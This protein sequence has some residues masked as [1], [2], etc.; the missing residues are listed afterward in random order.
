M[1]EKCPHCKSNQELSSSKMIKSPNHL[2]LSCYSLIPLAFKSHLHKWKSQ[3]SRHVMWDFTSMPSKTNG[4]C[5]L[6]QITEQC[7]FCNCKW[8]LRTGG[9]NILTHAK[10]MTLLALYKLH[11]YNH[12]CILSWHRKYFN[13]EKITPLW[14][15]WC[16]TGDFLLYQFHNEALQNSWSLVTNVISFLK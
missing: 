6:S 11:I 16:E 13:T 3:T 8:D 14:S 12:L 5:I 1:F 15:D 2:N 4:Y 7:T 9:R 10:Y